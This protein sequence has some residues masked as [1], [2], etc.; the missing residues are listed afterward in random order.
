M[1]FSPLVPI[2]AGS[3]RGSFVRARLL[4]VLSS[5]SQIFFFFVV[6]SCI[7][8]LQMLV[9][10]SFPNDMILAVVVVDALTL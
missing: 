3:F 1:G 5:L 8:A 9:S 2:P 7:A 6:I 4:G 10:S